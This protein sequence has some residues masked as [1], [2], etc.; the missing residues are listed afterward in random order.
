MCLGGLR[1][2]ATSCWAGPGAG[3]L[4]AATRHVVVHRGIFLLFEVVRAHALE[5][6][7]SGLDTLFGGTAEHD[8]LGR[9]KLA[10]RRVC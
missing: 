8:G 4:L 6:R 7:I 9:G 2:G 5:R 1:L 10:C 3:L